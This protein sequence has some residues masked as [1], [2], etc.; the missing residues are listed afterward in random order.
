MYNGAVGPEPGERIGHPCLDPALGLLSGR[1]FGLDRER[2][3]EPL[4]SLSNHLD[5][6]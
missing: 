3:G 5:L 6:L 4:E 1:R 2:L